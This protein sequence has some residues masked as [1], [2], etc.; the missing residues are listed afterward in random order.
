LFDEKKRPV[1]VAKELG[2]KNSTAFRYFQQWKKVGPNFEREYNFFKEALKT[3]SPGQDRLLELTAR[4]CGISKEELESLLTQPH[5]L[6]QLLTGK[7]PVPANEE[8][9]HKLQVA[10]ELG[11]CISNHLV[12]ERGKYEDVLYAFDRFMKVRKKQREIEDID[13]EEENEQIEFTRKLI[14]ADVQV[15]LEKRPKRDRLTDQEKNRIFR[16]WMDAKAKELEAQYLIRVYELMAE[17]LT[18]QQAR[19]KIYQDIVDK[20]DLKG[21]EMVRTYQETVHPL[22]T[23]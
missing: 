9:Y 5:G 14:E 17:G 8:R 19:E 1:D 7:F 15:E 23:G 6:K 2:M 18:S 22:E 3:P 20:G 12:E 21:A 13:I 16:W 11:L 4:T 10:L